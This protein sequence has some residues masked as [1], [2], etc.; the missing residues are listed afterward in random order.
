[1]PRKSAQALKPEGVIIKKCD[2]TAHN[3]AGNKACAARDAGAAK[4]KCQHTCQPGEIEQCHHKWT[5]VYSV[6]SR[7]REKSWATLAEA[8]R[9]QNDLTNGKAAQGKLFIDPAQGNALF[10]KLAEAVIKGSAR[11]EASANTRAGYLGFY[12][13][14]IAP[15][16][17]ARTLA[18][19][20]SGAAVDELNPGNVP[21]FLNEALKHLSKARR[22]IARMIIIYTMD[23]AVTAGRVPGH[24]LAGITLAEGTAVSRREA[25]AAAASDDD[26]SPLGFV[27]ITDDQVTALANGMTVT[28][29]TRRGQRQ[30]HLKGAGIAAW[31]Q[32]TMGLRICEALGVEKSDFKTRKNGQR[33]LKLRAQAT[34]DGRPAGNGK[35]RVPPKHRTEGQGRDVPV[36]DFVWDMVQAMPDGPLCPGATGKTRYMAYNT[37]WTRMG[38]LL[39]AMGIEGFTSH[40]LRHQ[41]ATE[42]L[43]DDPGQLASISAILGH[44]SVETTLRTSVHASADAE[45][46]VG[47]MMNARWAGKPGPARK[48][49]AVQA[50]R[51]A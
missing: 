32:R 16:Y 11:F 50:G 7:Q 15:V 27:F 17:A 30:H 8:Q 49:R 44:Q 18:W 31:L 14:H 40:S 21:S 36:P 46:Q 20:A 28:R 34:E 1:M 39:E 35:N 42:A 29:A 23:A 51:A 6:D 26:E 24:K 3:Q 10:G 5:N 38:L 45:T 33:Y 13:K 37:A 47:A 2:R 19:M 43:E 41:F 9:F 4:G 12:R 22:R 48:L 25:R